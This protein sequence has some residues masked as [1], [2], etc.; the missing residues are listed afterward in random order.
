MSDDI[1]DFPPLPLHPPRVVAARRGWQWLQES[2]TYFMQAPAVWLGI[3]A[4]LALIGVGIAL[5]PL[6]GV[7]ANMLL[8]PVWSAGVMVGCH[9]QYRGQPLRIQHI[10]AGFGPALKPLILLGLIVIALELIGVMVALGPMLAK[11][12]AGLDPEELQA[13]AMANPLPVL[14]QLLLATALLVPVAA[15]GWYAP[16]L[17]V[18]SGEGVGNALK[19]SLKA[20]IFNLWP[21]LI[22]SLATV[23]LALIG[24]IPFGLG[25][26]V[27]LP[28][29]IISVYLS[30]RDIF[31]D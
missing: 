18:L 6:L 24:S 7:L 27:V 19:L 5:I 15:A 3:L 8:P 21:L 12:A 31:V 13:E 28:M 29:M 25:L 14:L 30:Y 4:A 10:F 26:L 2:F 22:W 1:L 11:L 23:V 9:A 16:A 20:C 17:I